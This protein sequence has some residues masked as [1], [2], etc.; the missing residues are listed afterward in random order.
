MLEQMSGYHI[1]WW[2]NES[3]LLM[4]YK[5]PAVRELEKIAHVSLTVKFISLHDFRSKDKSLL[6]SESRK[7]KYKYH[8]ALKIK[9]I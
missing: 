8:S 9:I 5:N 4:N 1:T 3:K 6:V 7:M 2:L